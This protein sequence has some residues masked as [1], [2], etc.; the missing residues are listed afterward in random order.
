M[1]SFKNVL[2]LAPHTDDGE[3]GAGGF[4]AKLIDAGA[5]VTYIAFSI[6][7]ESVPDGFP[8]DILKT[9]VKLATATLGIKPERLIVFN[10][11]VRRFDAVRQEILEELIKI[12]KKNDFDLVLVPSMCDLHQDHSV[13]SREGVRAFKGTTILGYEL[14]WNKLSSSNNLFVKLESKHIERKIA[15]LQC[16]NSQ[17]GRSYVSKDF[18]FALAHTR[19]VQIGSQYAESFEVI[20]WVMN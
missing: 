8:K 12:R 2:I 13:I 16:Y 5:D 1:Y 9:E 6:A 10:F 20:R 19:G 14:I 18:V 17:Y 7:E 15:A 11:R 4:I 3:I